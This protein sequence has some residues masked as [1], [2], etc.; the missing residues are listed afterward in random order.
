MHN[1]SFS[2]ASI[3]HKCISNLILKADTGASKTFIREQ[4]ISALQRVK[5]IFNGPKARL[6]NNTVISP[7]AV[8]E[9]PFSNA[10]SRHAKESLVY[11]ELKNA[12]LL[13]IG[14]LCDDDCLALFHKKILW[15]LKNN[16]VILKGKRN[17]YDGIWDVPFQQPTS[18]KSVPSSANATYTANNIIHCNNLVIHSS[19]TSDLVCNYI[20]TL[21]KSKYELAQYYYGCLFA[22]A[23]STLLTAIQKENLVTWPGIDTINFKKYVGTNIAHEKGHLD[24]ER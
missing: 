21:D 23:L 11:P 16:E 18:P 13:S 1:T 4:D 5:T 2:V 20:L 17:S 22:P 9:L 15:I 3:I 14:Q 12:S 10:L 19:S 8:G 6:P 7:I 24:Q